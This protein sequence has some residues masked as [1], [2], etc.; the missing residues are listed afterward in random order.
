MSG[1]KA[2]YDAK[3]WNAALDAAAALLGKGYTF[4]RRPYDPKTQSYPVEIH[5][6]DKSVGGAKIDY[7]HCTPDEEGKD[8]AAILSLRRRVKAP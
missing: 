6:A 8:V 2:R 1:A 4:V 7:T 5:P 3:S